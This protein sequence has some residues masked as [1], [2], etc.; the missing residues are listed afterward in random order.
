VNISRPF[1]YNKPDIAIHG[2]EKV[3][4]V[5]I[6]V[7]I[8]GHIN[9]VKKEAEELMKYKNRTIEIKCVWNVKAKLMPVITGAS[10]TVSESF[11]K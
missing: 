11:I 6:D 1:P 3:K 4:R 2:N 8:S 5:L 10:G 7:A 9:V